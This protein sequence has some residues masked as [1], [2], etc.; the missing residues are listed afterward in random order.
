MEC[1]MDRVIGWQILGR[2]GP[3]LYIHVHC[4]T[5]VSGV[6]PKFLDA[7]SVPRATSIPCEGSVV[8]G[9]F[10]RIC[11]ICGGD[12]GYAYEKSDLES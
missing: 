3:P 2:E 12:K 6:S 10:S 9:F 4:R 5:C 8:R 11:S 7:L 1:P